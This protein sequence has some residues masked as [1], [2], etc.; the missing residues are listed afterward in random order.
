[1]A[2]LDGFEVAVS[3][4]VDVKM[5]VWVKLRPSLEPNINHPGISKTSLAANQEIKSVDM[6]I[7]LSVID[8]GVHFL[9]Q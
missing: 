2:G 6:V 1:V 4:F 9:P 3:D 5:V 8:S 7:I